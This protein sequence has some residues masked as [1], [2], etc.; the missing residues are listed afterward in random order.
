MDDIVGEGEDEH[1]EGTT[2]FAAAVGLA[3]ESLTGKETLEDVLADGGEKAVKDFET[4]V[5]DVEFDGGLASDVVIDSARVEAQQNHAG[6]DYEQ[7]LQEI[8]F[9]V[10]Q[11]GG[12]CRLDSLMAVDG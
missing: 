9:V 5:D 6:E 3:L 12:G 11:E 2:D 4:V 8:G 7:A 10:G 1:P